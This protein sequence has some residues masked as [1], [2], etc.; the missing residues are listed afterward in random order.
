[1]NWYTFVSGITKYTRFYDGNNKR[2]AGRIKS[3]SEHA[4]FY[5]WQMAYTRDQFNLQWKQAIPGNRAKYSGYH[6]A[7]VIQGVKRYGAQ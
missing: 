7:Y 2:S 5:R 4:I 1:M 3:T 6:D